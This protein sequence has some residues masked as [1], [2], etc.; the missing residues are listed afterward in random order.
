M[1]TVVL[2]TNNA[3]KVSEISN[4]L[5]FPGWEFKTLRQ[6]GIESD[7]EEDADSFL[8]NA[9]IKALAAHEASGGMAALADDSGIVVDALGGA[10]GVYSSRFAGEDATDQENNEKLLRDLEGVPDEQRTARFACTLVFIDEDG[11]EQTAHGTVEGR[12]GYAP[13][14]EGGF[15]YDPLFWPDVFNGTCTLAEVPQARKNEVSHRG[16]ALRELR[17]KLENV[18]CEEFLHE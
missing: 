10:P 11:S 16:N 15:G 13:Q 4:A 2:A 3:H 14:G 7:P 17:T 9:R 8:G 1:K 12:I 5:D 18:V 6:L